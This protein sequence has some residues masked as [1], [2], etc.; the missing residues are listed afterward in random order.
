M[1]VARAVPLLDAR[2]MKERLRD[3]VPLGPLAPLDLLPGLRPKLDVGPGSAQRLQHPAG[4]R[5]D[6]HN[7]NA[8]RAYRTALTSAGFG[9][10]AAKT[11]SMYGGRRNAADWPCITLIAQRL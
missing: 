7:P 4:A 9:S 8:P 6:V 11:P 1:L 3:L 5:L 2:Q 10:S